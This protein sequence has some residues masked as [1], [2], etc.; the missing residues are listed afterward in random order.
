MTKTCSKCHIE[1][2]L[3]EYSKSRFVNDK[4]YLHAYCK[5]CA[6][7]YRKKRYIVAKDIVAKDIVAKSVTKDPLIAELKQKFSKYLEDAVEALKQRGDK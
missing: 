7:E 1:K 5:Q 3:K 6:N 2:E 4:Q